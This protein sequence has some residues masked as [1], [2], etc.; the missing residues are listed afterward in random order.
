M[1]MRAGAGVGCA[2]AHP[3]YRSVTGEHMSQTGRSARSVLGDMQD[4]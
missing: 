3:D 4:T 1:R 2:D